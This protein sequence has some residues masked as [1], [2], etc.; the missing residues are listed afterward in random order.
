MDNYFAFKTK[1]FEFRVKQA[2]ELITRHNPTVGIIHENLL[3][4]FLKK[5]LPNWVTICEGFIKKGNDRNDISPQ[6]DI[7]IFNSIFY[8][9]FFKVEEILVLP[10]ESI[11]C[12]IEVKKN[13]DQKRFSDGLKNLLEVKRKGNNINTA[14]FIYN[15][16]SYET[17]S[18]YLKQFDFSN[19]KPEELPKRI[20]GLNKYILELIDLTKFGRGWCYLS[21]LEGK[22]DKEEDQVLNSF[23]YDIY[24]EIEKSINSSLKAG[25]VTGFEFYGEG[26]DISVLKTGRKKFQKCKISKKS[27]GVQLNFSK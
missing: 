18:K 16:P 6:V 4:E 26:D 2:E 1:E 8:S 22:N 7:L 17:I 24:E 11:I 15:P 23:F 20:Y 13:I 21:E 19:Y 10:P 5:H 25:I 12:A 3:R 27:K 14:F 9:P